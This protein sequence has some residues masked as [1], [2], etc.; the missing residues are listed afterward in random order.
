M[1]WG[2]VKGIM[3]GRNWGLVEALL[4]SFDFSACTGEAVKPGVEKDL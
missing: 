3:L 1:G 2:G 4:G